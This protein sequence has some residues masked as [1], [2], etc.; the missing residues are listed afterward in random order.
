MKLLLIGSG[1][2]G[3]RH[4]EG[5]LLSKACEDITV[6]DINLNALSDTK[7]FVD[8]LKLSKFSKGHNIRYTTNYKDLLPNYNITIIAT[9]VKHRLTAI[10]SLLIHSF[11]DILILEKILFS[12]EKDYIEVG[13]IIAKN[14]I[15]CYV[16]TA[17]RAMKS[18]KILKNK[19]ASESILNFRVSG[20]NWGLGTSAIHFIDIF[21][22]LND[23]Q[24]LCE[25][26][27][28]D[29]EIIENGKRPDYSEIYG[30]FTGSFKN[31]KHFEITSL[32]GRSERFEI[33]L[34]MKT[35]NIKI[36]EIEGNIFFSDTSLSA[37]FHLE[38]I[39]QV[40]KN[41]ITDISNNLPPMLA[42][43]DLSQKSHI[44]LLKAVNTAHSNLFEKLT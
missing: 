28:V 35:G 3:R 7:D 43:F 23:D 32:R 29:L 13:N 22:Y 21:Q 33:D 42:P 2:L 27:L 8:S 19:I 10:K 6:L 4:L 34:E 31:G 38:F 1:P 9:T 15:R 36:N 12:F 40:T 25:L 16:N 17:R 11:S 44:K 26:N 5:A 14:N 24:Q 30:I 20:T 37:P 18:Y 41:L 39:S